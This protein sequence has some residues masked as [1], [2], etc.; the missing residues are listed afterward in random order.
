MS[1]KSDGLIAE[2]LDNRWSFTDSKTNA[3]FTTA[4]IG[5][6]QSTREMRH[7]DAFYLSILNMNSTNCTVIANVRDASATG[8]V[9]AQFP[10]LVGASQ[11]AQVNV[12][13]IHL[14]ATQ[15]KGFV[16]N[17]TTVAPSVTATCN[18]AGWTDSADDH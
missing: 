5:D 2:S 4:L 16:V 15:G 6:T 1:K 18:A 3:A 12:S 9:L 8:T 10:F 17:L 13:D 11:V 7:M 14:V